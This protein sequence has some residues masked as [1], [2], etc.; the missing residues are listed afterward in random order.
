MALPGTTVL[1][2]AVAFRDSEPN[3][4]QRSFELAKSNNIE[5]DVTA[6][7]TIGLPKLNAMT[8]FAFR[9]DN[10]TNA[11]ASDFMA[12]NSNSNNNEG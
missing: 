8:L 12:F 6:S 3:S 1:P 7:P 10:L 2:A 9:G 4:L 5:P 11:F